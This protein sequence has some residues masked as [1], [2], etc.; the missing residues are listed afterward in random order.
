MQQSNFIMINIK[1]NKY[2]GDGI[3]I[4]H[5]PNKTVVLYVG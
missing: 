5:K 2:F 3:I 4:E 1:C